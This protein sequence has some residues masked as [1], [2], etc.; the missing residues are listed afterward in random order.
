MNCNRFKNPYFW[1]GVIGTLFTT[2]NVELSDITTWNILFETLTNI[3]Y[4]PF[5]LL[6][7]IMALIG[8][9]VDP[10]TKGAKDCKIKQDNI[11]KE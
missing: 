2:A 5:L 10:T 6:S 7:T 3:A 8:V 11:N 1:I 4:N 9:F